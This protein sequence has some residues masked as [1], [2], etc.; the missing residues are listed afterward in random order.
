MNWILE[1]YFKRLAVKPTALL[2]VKMVVL[3]Q[4]FRPENGACISSRINRH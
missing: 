2:D 3:E 4:H 1:K